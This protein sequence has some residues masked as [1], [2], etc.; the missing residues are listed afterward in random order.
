M[1]IWIALNTQ[2][3]RRRQG[4]RKEGINSEHVIQVDSETQHSAISVSNDIIGIF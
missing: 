1:K 3:N 4:G 2:M